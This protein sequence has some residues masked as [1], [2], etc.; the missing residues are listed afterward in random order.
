[1][2]SISQPDVVNFRL[3]YPSSLFVLGVKIWLVVFCHSKFDG[4]LKKNL[5]KNLIKKKIPKTSPDFLYMI[6]SR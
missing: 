2:R 6:L 5:A 1:M 3:G 4:F